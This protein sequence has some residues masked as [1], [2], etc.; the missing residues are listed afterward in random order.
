VDPDTLEPTGTDELT[1]IGGPGVEITSSSTA[2][3]FVVNLNPPSA[4]TREITLRDLTI[5]VPASFPDGG[6]SGYGSGIYLRDDHLEDVDFISENTWSTMVS[7]IFGG[8]TIE[9]GTY[10]AVEGVS[11]GTGIVGS[12][13]TTG[14]VRIDGVDIASAVGPSISIGAGNGAYEITS[15][16]LRSANTYP[17][18]AGNSGNIDSYSLKRKRK[19]QKFVFSVR[20]IDAAGNKDMSPAK[21]AVRVAKKKPKKR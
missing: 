15:S 18:L 17:A 3:I 9:G 8:A 21:A 2:N 4:P 10:R 5:R 14:T 13:F 11:M 1:V 7:Q 12:N 19:P 6:L 20:A 16:R